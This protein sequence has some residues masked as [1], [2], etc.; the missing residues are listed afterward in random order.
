[1]RLGISGLLPVVLDEIDATAIRRVRQAG[2]SG[3][4]WPGRIPLDALTPTCCAEL[5]AAFAGAGVD[6]VEFGQYQTTLVDPDPAVRGH[7]IA[8]L[9]H[10]CR[11]A[12]ALGC[13]A[14]I[15]G[16]GLSPKFPRPPG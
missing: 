4:A 13:P 7:T 2:F 8:T 12:R 6:L 5:R 9:R 16:V 14:V 11:L 3:V 1:M 15:A 10:A